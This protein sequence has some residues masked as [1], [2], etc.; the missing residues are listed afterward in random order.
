VRMASPDESDPSGDGLA[1]S[2]S[3]ADGRSPRPPP[4]G[5]GE[6]VLYSGSSR[7]RLRVIGGAEADGASLRYSHRCG[8]RATVAIL[9]RL[10]NCPIDW[11]AAPAD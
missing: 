3:A 10:A 8:N 2:A 6:L 5:D 9:G 7:F 1:V 11:A 4:S